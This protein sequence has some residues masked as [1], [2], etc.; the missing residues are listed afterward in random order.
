[1]KKTKIL[2]LGLVLVLTF[3]YGNSQDFNKVWA[4]ENMSI[5]GGEND[6]GTS[7][8]GDKISFSVTG[9]GEEGRT[10]L[11]YGVYEHE[12][13]K[14]KKPLLKPK[15]NESNAVFTSDLKTMY[16]TRSLYGEENTLKYGEDVK[17]VLGL[18]SA[19]KASDGTWTKITSLPFNSEDYDVGHPALSPDNKKLYFSSNMKGTMGGSDIFVVDILGDNKFSEPVNLGKSVNS[20]KADLYPFISSE[21]ILYF[22][23][24]RS[25]G[26]GNI[27]IYEVDLNT[28]ALEVKLLPKPINSKYDDFSYIY[29]HKQEIGFFSSNRPG[30]R[31]GDDIYLLK[32][33]EIEKEIQV[34]V[35][36]VKSGCSQKLI[37]VVFLNATQTRIGKALVK[38]KN[39][40]N[41]VVEVV[42]TNHNAKYIF[43]VKCNK[44]YKIE[45]SRKGYETSERIMIT[46]A[47]NK[48]FAKK[49]IF[50]NEKV[51]EGKKQEYLYVGTVDFDYNKWDLQKHYTYELDKA[52]QLMKENKKLVIHFES[53]TDSRAPVEF[54]L[55]L[56]DKRIEVLKEYIGFQGI[57]RKRFSGESFGERKPINRCVKGVQCSDAEYLANRRTIFYLKEAK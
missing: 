16:F 29:N 31:G 56:S 10:H 24:N 43:N 3:Q 30:G 28:G 12:D 14:S 21:N 38:L 53:H 20:K 1:M 55:D 46:N 11:F 44:K 47:D 17:S 34:D 2:I 48:A 5:N 40:D 8:Y 50:L 23:S 42:K 6:F 41:K 33:V 39:E 25:H 51:K 35:V 13:I 32:K 15:T 9:G 19:I 37:G 54:N 45:A 4:V 7:Y 18:F 26:I 57:F 52:V 27:D 22:S 36:E 49:N